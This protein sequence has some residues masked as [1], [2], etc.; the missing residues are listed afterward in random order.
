MGAPLRRRLLLPLALLQAGAAGEAGAEDERELARRGGR[1]GLHPRRQ[2]TRF[3]PTATHFASPSPPQPAAPTAPPHPPEH[4]APPRWA[5]GQ[6]EQGAPRRRPWPWLELAMA[7]ASRLLR[8][9]NRP[10]SGS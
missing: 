10:A 1:R 4:A 7:Q 8:A 3:P 6:P 2:P 9:W 5:L